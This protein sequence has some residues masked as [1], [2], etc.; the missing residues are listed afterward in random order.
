MMP[1]KL[2]F[3]AV[4]VFANPRSEFQNFLDELLPGEVFNVFVHDGRRYL[5]FAVAQKATNLWRVGDDDGSV[6]S[7]PD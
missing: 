5:N 1:A 7:Q 2:L 3:T 6:E 4:A